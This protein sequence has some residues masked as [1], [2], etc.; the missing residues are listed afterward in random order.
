MIETLVGIDE[1]LMH[2]INVSLANRLFDVVMPIV[3]S[4]YFVRSVLGGAV[5]VMAWKGGKYGLITALL[6]ILTVLLSDQMSSQMIKPWVGRLRPC[7]ELEWVNVLVNCSSGK[8]FP[9]SH[10]VNSFA[11]AVLWSSRYPKLGYFAYPLASLIAISRVF[12][13]VH[14]PLDIV[15]GAIVGSICAGIIIL[16]YRF[17]LS[18]IG[19]LNAP[20]P[21]KTP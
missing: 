10:A 1:Q 17:G 7:H 14:Y 18:R 8:S 3:T 16:I 2:F 6:A 11:Q 19:I 4:E 9:S 12:V 13:G 5:V 15:A 21:I 20:H